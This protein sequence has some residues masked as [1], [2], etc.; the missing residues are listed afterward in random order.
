MRKK[1]K[2]TGRKIIENLL[3]FII[4]VILIAGCVLLVRLYIIKYF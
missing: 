2:N 1:K 4:S 3:L